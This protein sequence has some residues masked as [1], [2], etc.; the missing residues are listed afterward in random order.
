[1]T[2]LT[3]LAAPD[4]DDPLDFTPVPRQRM[5]KGGWSAARQREFIALLAETGSVRSACRRMGVGE[6]QVYVLRN[7]PEAA[8]FRRAWEAALDCGI[9]RIE[10]TAM[11]RALYGTEDPIFWQGEQV[12]TRRHYNDRLLMFILRNR[13]PERFAEGKPKGLGAIDTRQLERL[14]KQWRKE[15][16]QESAQARNVT[17]AEVRASIDRKVEA[18]RLR[19]EAERTARRA[20]LS[21]ETLAAF[22]HF[23]AL[24]DRDL[25][26]MDASERTRRMVEVT[27]ETKSTHFDP[28]EQPALSAPERAAGEE[29]WHPPDGYQ[30]WPEREPEPPRTEWSLKDEGFDP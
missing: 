10:D 30:R 24:R 12:G 25:A 23:C 7:H 4:P 8:S 27:L 2:D 9:A 29:D 14:K 1:M 22:A 13:A 11:D 18:I 5:R 26:A 17:A 21:E 20:A 3:P 28:P 19:L 15:W 6:H 16:E